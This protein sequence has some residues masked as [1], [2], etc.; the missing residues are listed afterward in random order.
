LALLSGRRVSLFND[1]LIK[2]MEHLLAQKWNRK[3]P[4]DWA[5]LDNP[6]DPESF[7]AKVNYE[8]RST[9]KAAFIID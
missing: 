1:S 7:E 6:E 2:L 9:Q 5:V 8:R 3:E 4:K